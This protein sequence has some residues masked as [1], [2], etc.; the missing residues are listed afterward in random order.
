MEL[1]GLAPIHPL[2]LKYSLFAKQRFLPIFLAT[3]LGAFNDNLLRSGLVV[4]IAYS[5]SKGIALP[6]KPEILVTI[7]SALLVVPLL[8]FSYISGTLADKYEKSKLV[9]ITKLIEVA[10]MATAFF[11]FATQNITLLMCLLFVSGMHTTF[12]SPIKF[13]ILPD[14][15]RSGE[16]LAANGFMAG[17]SYLAVLCGLIAG[18]LLVEMPGNVIG[19][20]AL[21]I[22]FT[23]LLASLFILPS[24]IAHPDT[25]VSFNIWKGSKEIIGY[26]C[27]DKTVLL[28]IFA[29][30]W[31]LLVGSVFMSQ[32]ANY[33]QGVVHGNN[34][35]YILLLTVFSIG[36]AIGSLMC[37]TL[38][39]GQISAK[40]TP[41]AALGVSIFTYVMVAATPKTAS[42]G[43]LDV[44]QF[45]AMPPHWVILGS[46][47]MVALCGGIYLVP[48]YAMLQA[49][50]PAQ[51]RS[52]IMAAS[53]LS[54][55]V[56]LTTA[57]L[58]SAVLLSFGFG[59]TDLFLLV[60]TLNLL[61]VY[62]ARKVTA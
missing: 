46:I 36:I 3:F 8:L 21:G 14:H 42:P 59:V 44:S 6:A 61:V 15:L 32:F 54:D 7:C 56:L 25:R 55:S 43:L 16:L 60:A 23:G 13:S 18:G 41:F 17:G 27:R 29:L 49:H 4:L 57:A 45:I 11:G 51:F 22:A 9:K 28:S 47:T 39:K 58:V 20:T 38:L 48:L 1:E 50:T 12:Y 2:N 19:I 30:S 33:A 35:V 40:L 52:R 37:D 10:I 62:Y 24:H 31:F 34:E 5:A 53:N 26:A